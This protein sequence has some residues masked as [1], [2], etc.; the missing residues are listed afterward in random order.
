MGYCM[1]GAYDCPRCRP[2]CDD[3]CDCKCGHTVANHETTE[4]EICLATLCP[5]CE[6]PDCE[7]LTDEERRIIKAGK[8]LEHAL[9]WADGEGIGIPKVILHIR[10]AIRI[11]KGIS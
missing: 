8:E 1:C 11:L 9:Y 6:C 10:R 3:P 2:G 4:C 7:D 5:D